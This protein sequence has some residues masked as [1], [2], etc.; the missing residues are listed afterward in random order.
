MGEQGANGPFYGMSDSPNPVI[1][2]GGPHPEFGGALVRSVVPNAHIVQCQEAPP[3]G[4][5]VFGMPFDTQGV[6]VYQ[7]IEMFN[8][9][10]HLVNLASPW[11]RSGPP[12]LI[13]YI[14]GAAPTKLDDGTWRPGGQQIA[15]SLIELQE[16]LTLAGVPT[17]APRPPLGAQTA[18]PPEVEVRHD[19]M[20]R[21]LHPDRLTE[22]STI[23]AGKKWRA[24]LGGYDHAR[25]MLGLWRQTSADAR[26]Q[27]ILENP[28]A[29]DKLAY[30]L[31]RS[32]LLWADGVSS[33]IPQILD[34]TAAGG[35]LAL[36]LSALSW[37]ADYGTD[38]EMARAKNAWEKAR[39]DLV[40]LEPS[41]IPV[42]P[43]D[44]RHPPTAILL[45][46]TSRRWGLDDLPAE[47][48][49]LVAWWGREGIHLTGQRWRDAFRFLS[50]SP[51]ATIP[52]PLGEILDKPL[53]GGEAELQ[54]PL[55]GLDEGT[56]P[57]SVV[58]T[59]CSLDEAV[60]AAKDGGEE[61]KY[62]LECRMRKIDAALLLAGDYGAAS[63][64][65]EVTKWLSESP[66]KLLFR[67]R[68]A[69]VVSS[70]PTLSRDLAEMAEKLLSSGKGKV[71]RG[72]G[73]G[74]PAD[75]WDR[76]PGARQR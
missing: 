36:R 46:W 60:M 70:W 12:R 9:A 37:L 41:R 73:K 48:E 71:G 14:A 53:D 24:S 10:A 61:S 25:R 57:P 33:M 50:I 38:E 22:W 68:V 8:E 55:G 27:Y 26:R 23:Q 2:V 30:A 72:K 66:V 35:M 43:S 21:A 13:V 40:V 67:K 31:P 74:L 76:V 42:R 20:P 3:E 64:D 44:L 69:R 65:V 39:A 63:N 54:K 1:Y 52:D 6:G 59:L 5:V 62:K 51:Y 11:D 45:R 34:G 4:V 28:A 19:K 17:T 7:R 29:A 18:P 15:G 49:A 32:A 47:D 16:V 56:L 58:E 75:V